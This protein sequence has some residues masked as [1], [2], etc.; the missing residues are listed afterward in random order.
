MKDFH[1][2][3][4]SLKFA[5]LFIVV[6]TTFNCWNQMIPYTIFGLSSLFSF[7]RSISLLCQQLI[8][9]IIFIRRLSTKCFKKFFVVL[10]KRYRVDDLNIISLDL[11]YCQQEFKIS[12]PPH[13]RPQQAICIYYPLQEPLSTIFQYVFQSFCRCLLKGLFDG[14]STGMYL[15]VTLHFQLYS[16]QR[17]NTISC[18]MIIICYKFLYYF[19]I[20]STIFTKFP[21]N[22]LQ[23]FAIF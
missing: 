4:C 21:S 15:I 5:D 18:G 2:L 13:C 6:L 19:P 9:H 14:I 3:D 12:F 1:E 17:L 7:Q 22:Y 23:V 10:Y 16:Q 11:S 8:Y 20:Q